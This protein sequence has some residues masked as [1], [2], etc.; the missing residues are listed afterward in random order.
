MAKKMG[1][2][3]LLWPKVKVNVRR[4]KMAGKMGSLGLLYI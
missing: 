2:L 3:G 4:R 1:S